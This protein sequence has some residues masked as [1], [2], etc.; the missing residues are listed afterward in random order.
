M[1]PNTHPALKSWR[2]LPREQFQVAVGEGQAA[3][4]GGGKDDKNQ[5][6]RKRTLEFQEVGLD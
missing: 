2:S 4:V 6:K 1:R 3:E 5:Q